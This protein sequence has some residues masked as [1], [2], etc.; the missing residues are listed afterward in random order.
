MCISAQ[1]NLALSVHNSGRASMQLVQLSIND[2]LDGRRH[3]PHRLV[4][5][6]LRFRIALCRARKII[7][8]ARPCR[9]GGSPSACSRRKKDSAVL[10]W[11]FSLQLILARVHFL[12][13]GSWD[14]TLDSGTLLISPIRLLRQSC[15]PLS[16]F[17]RAM[18]GEMLLVLKSELS[19]SIF[20]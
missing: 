8:A 18:D 15:L 7:D 11:L 20:K 4:S 14:F 13:Y 5:S 17:F 19:T 12:P 3:E 6:R 16:R 10:R 9:D 2:G 1:R